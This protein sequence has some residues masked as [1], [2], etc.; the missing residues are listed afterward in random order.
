MIVREHDMGLV[1]I[2]QHEHGRLAGE[3]AKQLKAGILPPDDPYTDDLITAVYEHDRG[4]IALDKKPLW[5]EETGRP[6]TF[7]D[8]PLEPKLEAYEQG[9]NEV[10][11]MSPY[12]GLICSLHFVSFTQQAHE[13]LWQQFVR[14][15]EQRQ[16]RLRHQLSIGKEDP[17]VLRH[18]RLLQLC[19]DLSLYISLN[20]PGVDKEEEHPWFREGF[21]NTEFLNARSAKR[22]TA[23]WKEKERVEVLPSPFSEAFEVTITYRKLAKERIRL[24]GGETAYRASTPRTASLWIK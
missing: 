18:F 23:F 8:Y 9:L 12:A 16:E 17:A 3:F 24:M 14:R 4:W 2:E 13:R 20:E 7:V 5:N 10:E 11:E 1:M 22:L 6:Y 15:E 19:D 21:A